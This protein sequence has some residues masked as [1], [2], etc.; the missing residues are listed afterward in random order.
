MVVRGFLVGTLAVALWRSLHPA[1]PAA[2]S[3]AATVRE[4]PAALRAASSDARIGALHLVVDSLP[5]AN[6]RD[7]LAALRRAGVVVRWQGSPPALALEVERS[8]E[9]ESRVRL[10]VAADSGAPFVITDSA[11]ALDSLRVAAGGATLES[12]TVVGRAS[13]ARGRWRVSAAVP[14]APAPRAVLVLGRAGW[15]SKF[16]AAA[17]QEAGWT[18][19]ARLPAAPGVVVADPAL[20]PVDSSR[21]AA[22][23]AL[24]SSATD[25]AP[26]LARFVAQGG[27]LVL[28]GEAPSVASLR[29]LAP[30]TTSARRPGRILL[31]GDSV[32]RADLPMRPLDAIRSD[33][34]RLEGNAGQSMVA[35]RRAGLGRVLT[36]G[37]D[38]SWRWRM[39]GG[40]SGLAAHRAWWS[41][42]VGLVAAEGPSTSAPVAPGGAPTAALVGALGPPTTATGP[43]DNS[44]APGLP[45]IMLIAVVLLLLA[46]TTS[47]RFRGAR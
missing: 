31:D 43:R 37:Y 30:A 25:L 22:V 34:V 10:L 32:T 39:L 21:Y 8:R 11:G 14:P 35:A 38:E 1:L 4:L 18:V 23:I 3:R 42:I 29:A 12:P 5:E 33:A 6:E 44:R 41:H 17:L 20:L 47:R 15:E 19:R 7:W 9:P 24:D 16:V 27:G 28:A 13:A 45:L 36:V 40:T 2:L 26:V 46:E